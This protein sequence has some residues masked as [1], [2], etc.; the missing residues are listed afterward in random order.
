MIN[1]TKMCYLNIYILDQPPDNMLSL[2]N[3]MNF[4]L[5]RVN[6]CKYHCK[7]ICLHIEKCIIYL[8]YAKM[9]ERE[10]QL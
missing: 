9:I 2:I 5:I 1:V 8:D 4:K 7:V 6:S 3:D 10:E